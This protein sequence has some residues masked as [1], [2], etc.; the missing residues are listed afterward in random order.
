M[1]QITSGLS[2]SLVLSPILPAEELTVGG[3]DPEINLNDS[4][5][6]LNRELS[7]LQFNERVLYQAKNKKNPL[8]ERV[9]VAQED[10]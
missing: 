8:L 10:R 1:D 4:S 6:Y 3:K 9:V 7:W 5:L 2:D